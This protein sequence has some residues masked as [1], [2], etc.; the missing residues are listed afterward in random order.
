MNNSFMLVFDKENSYKNLLNQCKEF[1]G[2]GFHSISSNLT[3]FVHKDKKFILRLSSSNM[4]FLFAEDIDNHTFK[5]ALNLIQGFL[6]RNFKDQLVGIQFYGE[7]KENYFS[8][9]DE[10]ETVV[11]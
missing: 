9:L 7:R 1:F 3:N 8:N 11:L 2:A 5:Q 4:H 6:V 10:V